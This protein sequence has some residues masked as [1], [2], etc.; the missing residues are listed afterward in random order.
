MK[1]TSF[2][3][4]QEDIDAVIA[5]IASNS[6]DSAYLR[7]VNLMT[8][9][10]CE[11]QSEVLDHVHAPNEHME[12]LF[13]CLSFYMDILIVKLGLS[14]ENIERTV[15]EQFMQLY[16][17]MKNEV[18]NVPENPA[19]VAQRP[20]VLEDVITKAADAIKESSKTVQ[21]YM[22]NA[23]NASANMTAGMGE[24]FA[25]MTGGMMGGMGMPGM[26]VPP[27]VVDGEAREVSPTPEIEGE[28]DPQEDPQDAQ[29][30]APAEE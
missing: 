4:R 28:Q 3:L 7:G 6:D 9:L 8:T 21:E 27:D 16:L 12:N 20:N 29:E 22:E 15:S 2:T 30:D 19:D 24:A 26:D 23:A 11:L 14:K 5:R 13:G 17:Q 1:E 25:A 18:Q 10:Q